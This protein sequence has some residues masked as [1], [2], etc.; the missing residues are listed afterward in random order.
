[1]EYKKGL[2]SHCDFTRF[3][4]CRD[5]CRGSI[6]REEGLLA[7]PILKLLVIKTERAKIKFVFLLA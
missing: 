2:E 4:H 7:S 3:L 1:M 5:I 6:Y